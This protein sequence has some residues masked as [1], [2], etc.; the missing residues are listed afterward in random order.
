MK[1]SSF[2]LL[3]FAGISAY[4][5]ATPSYADTLYPAGPGMYGGNAYQ[6][7]SGDYYNSNPK[8]GKGLYGGGVIQ[9]KNGRNYNCNRYGQCTDAGFSW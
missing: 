1:I 9:D 2:L 4:Q 7:S 5:V 8:Y 6:D 3:L